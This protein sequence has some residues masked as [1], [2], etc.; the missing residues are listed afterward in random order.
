MYKYRLLYFVAF[1]ACGAQLAYAGAGQTSAGVTTSVGT[2]DPTVATPNV[3]TQSSNFV[4]QNQAQASPTPTSVNGTSVVSNG[5]KT[6]QPTDP[7]NPGKA[8]DPNAN[9]NAPGNA[10]PA[11][12]AVPP[13][14]PP[15]YV[16][17]IKK[18]DRSTAATGA[19][20][21]ETPVASP[22]GNSPVRAKPTT[23]AADPA[24]SSLPSAP[25]AQSQAAAT[26]PRPRAAVAQDVDKRG[27]D[28]QTPI[29]TGA[30]GGSGAAPDSYAFYI[31]LIIAGALL[32]FAAATYLRA[33]KGGDSR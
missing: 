8:G 26:A 14:P 15:E 25:G 18:V 29:Q 5:T 12:P 10:A 21:V 17:N 32:A 1:A 13:P 30:G 20:V 6:T 28:L 19:A 24:V 31:G 33:E 16:S 22:A 9:P 2:T 3:Q 11:A 7:N 4:Q 23:A 27:G